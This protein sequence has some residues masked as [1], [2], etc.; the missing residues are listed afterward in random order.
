MKTI[1]MSLDLDSI[2]AAIRKVQAYKKQL[3]DKINRLIQ[4]LVD[5]GVG[6]AKAQVQQLAAVYTGELQNSIE[7]YFDSSSRVGI[8]KAGAWYAV[9]VEFGTGIIGAGS[10][11]PAPA[12]ANWIYDVN[13]HGESGWWY[14]NDRDGRMHWTQGMESR[15]F[16][17]YT[18]HI[19]GQKCDE[20]A[21]EVFHRD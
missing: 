15:P 4:T 9:Y 18:A 11:H 14:Y 1:R 12:S 3:E 10:P 8:I 5:Y 6:V 20:I 16:M 17:Y 7:G 13:E 21:K 2:D 19:L